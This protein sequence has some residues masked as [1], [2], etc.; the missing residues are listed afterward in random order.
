MI[1]ATSMLKLHFTFSYL[2]PIGEFS[3]RKHRPEFTYCIY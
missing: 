1:V 3:G 2:K